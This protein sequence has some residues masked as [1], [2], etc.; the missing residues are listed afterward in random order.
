MLFQTLLLQMKSLER[1]AAGRIQN[2]FEDIDPPQCNKYPVSLC[3]KDSEPFQRHIILNDKIVSAVLHLETDNKFQN[4][5]LPSV[6]SGFQKGTAFSYE[7]LG[8]S[9]S[10]NS[11]VRLNGECLADAIVLAEPDTSVS[12]TLKPV[13]IE[14]DDDVSLDVPDKHNI[15]ILPVTI[16]LVGNHGIK[17]GSF[18]NELVLQ[19]ITDYYPLMK[20]WLSGIQ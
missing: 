5:S 4:I 1:N 18:D 6:T 20:S 11:P 15:F 16:P 14:S 8:A 10:Q 7:F 3:M 19:S 17:C 2:E 13:S 9:T 12:A